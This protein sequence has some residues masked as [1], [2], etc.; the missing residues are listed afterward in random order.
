MFLKFKC[1]FL[2]LIFSL[3]LNEA[4]SLQLRN[5]RKPTPN[6]Q[7]PLNLNRSKIFGND[8]KSNLSIPSLNLVVVGISAVLATIA[9]L[10]LRIPIS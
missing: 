1:L 9:G 4:N 3:L 6:S 7:V 8:V 2:I 5:F 10:K